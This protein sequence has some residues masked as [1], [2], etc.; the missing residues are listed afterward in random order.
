M[1]ATPQ[2]DNLRINTWIGTLAVHGSYLSAI[3][4]NDMIDLHLTKRSNSFYTI[5]RLANLNFFDYFHYRNSKEKKVEKCKQAI[6]SMC[7]RS[8]VMLSNYMVFHSISRAIF[9]IRLVRITITVQ[10]KFDKWKREFHLLERCAVAFK[11]F[12]QYTHACT[13][14]I[15]TKTHRPISKR[16]IVILASLFVVVI[17]ERER[18]T[19][20]EKKNLVVG[21]KRVHIDKSHQ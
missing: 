8:N 3:E 21:C 6:H 7:P 9:S 20:N 14:P 11:H 2:I 16:T 17:V 13:L 5:M 12:Q 18:E 19:E 10:F 15:T 1:L 4:S